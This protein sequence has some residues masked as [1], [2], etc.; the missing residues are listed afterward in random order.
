MTTTKS[1]AAR[2]VQAIHD[3]MR[4][5]LTRYLSAVETSREDDRAGR[6]RPL[7]RWAEGFVHELHVHHG[8]EDGT[9]FPS[10]AV[11]AP[12]VREVLTSLEEDHRE[13]AGLL[14]R[15]GPAARA[16][17]G[18]DVPFTAARDEAAGIVRSLRGLLMPH[19][20]IEDHVVF[21]MYYE[22]FSAAEVEEQD[23]AIK[24][25]LPKTGLWFA[26]P[27]NVAALPD[28]DRE[29]LRATAPWVLRALHRCY[30]PRY[31]RLVAAAFAGVP[32]PALV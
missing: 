14:E 21:P 6:L 24:K 26:L 22:R 27:W 3:Q 31:E 28:E 12:E 5:D 2:H 25:S 19:L 8:I 1:P 23:A 7:A 11:R 10:L 13:V 4:R 29:E 20:D 16:L 15:W 32:E 9:I 18:R 30:A 17:A